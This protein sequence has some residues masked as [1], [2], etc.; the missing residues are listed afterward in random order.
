M[1]HRQ[2]W[3]IALAVFVLKACYGMYNT[4]FK[5]II[6]YLIEIL[7]FLLFLLYAN[8]GTLKEEK[9]GSRLT[10]CVWGGTMVLRRQLA[11]GL[12]WNEDAYAKYKNNYDERM[13]LNIKTFYTLSIMITWWANK[14]VTV[15]K[16]LVEQMFF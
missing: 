13:T 16:M 9:T 3:N 5:F 12:I 4:Y 10:G 7:I 6:F 14:T 2:A 1:I 11:T 8:T 15:Y